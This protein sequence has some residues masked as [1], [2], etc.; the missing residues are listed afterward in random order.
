MAIP[1]VTEKQIDFAADRL[2][3]E[4]LEEAVER[5]GRAQ[6]GI[7]AFLLSEA[8]D[9]LFPEERDF[10]LYLTLIIW[11]AS[12]DAAT[13]EIPIIAQDAIGQREEINWGIFEE[14]KSKSFRQKMDAFF[15]D[16]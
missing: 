12:A 8:F 15:E 13:E 7:L 14:A 11:N 5:F 3:P 1:F 10:M 4:H 9:V 16:T 2:N 6:P